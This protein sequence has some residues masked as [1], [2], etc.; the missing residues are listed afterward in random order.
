MITVTHDKEP[1]WWPA[2]SCAFCNAPTRYWYVPKDVAVCPSCAEKHEPADVPCKRQ[3]LNE[4]RGAGEKPLPDN[5]QCSADRR[6]A[7]AYPAN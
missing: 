3:W 4:N 5:W 6:A 2:E 7:P 1:N